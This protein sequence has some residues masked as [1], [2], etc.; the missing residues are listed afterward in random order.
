MPFRVP[1]PARGRSDSSQLLCLGSELL[2]LLGEQRG[3]GQGRAHQGT[4]SAHGGAGR[5]EGRG[6]QGT[7]PRASSICH[8]ILEMKSEA[9]LCEAGGCW[10][11][12]WDKG[13]FCSS[14]HGWRE[15]WALLFTEV[16]CSAP[17]LLHEPL[18]LEQELV[19]PRYSRSTHRQQRRMK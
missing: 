8:N 14:S 17:H 15:G 19:V 16:D 10:A 7:Q 18:E 9:S 12:S 4:V 6:A 5:G 2:M 13:C 1:P 11:H 3:Q